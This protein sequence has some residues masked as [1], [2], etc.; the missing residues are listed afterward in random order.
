M[1][2]IN[3]LILNPL[4]D[5]PG[6]HHAIKESRRELQGLFE[7]ALQN[8]HYCLNALAKI[9]SSFEMFET[10]FQ[11]SKKLINSSLF[12]AT[13]FKAWD[14][15]KKIL[16]HGAKDKLS[17]GNIV[18]VC[19]EAITNHQTDVVQTILKN[20]TPLLRKRDLEV[21][22][23]FVEPSLAKSSGFVEAEGL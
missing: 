5:C 2:L 13:Y 1:T 12:V 3:T 18:Y 23:L 7:S 17:L 22:L 4:T 8:S 21:A 15:V 20:H 14:L 19:W 16:S 11:E 9:E 10:D 6:P